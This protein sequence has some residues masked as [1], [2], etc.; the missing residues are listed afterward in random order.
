[1]KSTLHM[2]QLWIWLCGSLVQYEASWEGSCASPIKLLPM[3][4]L[5]PLGSD[6]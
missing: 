4:G 1:M 6:L 3:P 5:G 2:C